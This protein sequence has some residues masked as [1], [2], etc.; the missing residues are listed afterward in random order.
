MRRMELTAFS[1]VI[2]GEARHAAASSHTGSGRLRHAWEAAGRH[3]H[4]LGDAARQ[5][6]EM[7]HAGVRALPAQA[8]EAVATALSHVGYGTVFGYMALE[9]TFLPLVAE[10][11][12]FPAGVAA[13]AGHLTWAGALAAAVAGSLLGSSLNYL[14]GRLVPESWVDN[15]LRW[16]RAKPPTVA[17]LRAALRDEAAMMLFFARFIPGVRHF[18]GLAAGAWRVPF[19]TY[20]SAT[21]AGDLLYVPAYFFAAYLSGGNPGWWT[22]G[23]LGAA[24]V[25]MSAAGVLAARHALRDKKG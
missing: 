14:L 13:A 15:M 20:F 24:G 1:G 25:G 6:G 2:S 21:A 16:A 7:A 18:I 17:R 22:L 10:G 4:D 23:A 5:A 9:S 3:A 19:R 11:A 8:H 12:L